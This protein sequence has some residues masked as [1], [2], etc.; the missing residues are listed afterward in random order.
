MSSDKEYQAN[1][2]MR[3]VR[4]WYF[5][6][7]VRFAKFLEYAQIYQGG[8]SFLVPDVDICWGDNGRVD[9]YQVWWVEVVGVYHILELLDNWYEH[10]QGK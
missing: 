8:G 6:D 2:G 10:F 3:H 1:T 4:R 7:G 9:M 5:A